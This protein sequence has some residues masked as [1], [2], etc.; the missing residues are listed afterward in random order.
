MSTA[1][2]VLT[3]LIL[4]VMVGWIVMMSAVAQLNHNWAE[5]V[6]KQEKEFVRIADEAAT[7]KASYLALT[8]QA[9]AEQ[10]ATHRDVRVREAQLAAADARRSSKVEDLT[11][12]KAQVADYEAA[13]Q[14][15][16]TN[17]ATREAE[18]AKDLDD[19]AKKRD[20]IAKLQATNAELRSQLAQ[21]Q[22]EF[23][24]L[25]A[26]NTTEVN[27]ASSKAPAARPASS[28]RESPSS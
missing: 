19:L 27:K 24:R 26:E 18:K 13:V 3:V 9:R 16:T 2:K 1:G 20:E 22:E 10:D 15:S 14:K 11:R 12:L 8:E 17:L 28:R 5:K 7:A 23:K 25:L 6:D 4:L 21:L